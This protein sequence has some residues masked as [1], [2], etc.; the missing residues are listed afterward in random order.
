MIEKDHIFDK[1]IIDR[2]I[3]R[4]RLTPEQYKEHLASLKDVSANVEEISVEVK[5]G[6]FKVEFPDPIDADELDI[7]EE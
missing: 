5:E 4:G 7:D 2:N 6:E 3:A 1:R